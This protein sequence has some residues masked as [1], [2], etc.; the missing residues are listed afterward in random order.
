[1]A[2]RYPNG[3]PVVEV[4]VDDP[5]MY[6]DPSRQGATFAFNVLRQDGTYV[7]WTDIE[8]LANEAGV[9]IRAGGENITLK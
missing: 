9:Y 1:M 5:T 7:P 2:L 4:Y 8:R 3:S 6:G